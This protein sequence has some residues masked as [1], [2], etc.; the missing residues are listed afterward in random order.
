MS[1]FVLAALLPTR[2]AGPEALEPLLEPIRAAR[3][4]PALAAAV[5]RDGAIIAVG[6]TG[7]RAEG[8]S[9]RVT[10]EDR[11]HIGSCTKAMTATLAAILVERGRL[12]W[13]TTVPDGLPHLADGMHEGWKQA[14][15]EML[16]QNRGGLPN[17][18]WPPGLDGLGV[19]ML[20]KDPEEQ[21]REFVRRHLAVAPEYVPG[22]RFVYSNAGY[23]VAGEMLAKAGGASYEDLL[24][25]EVLS[26]L[27]IRSAGFGAAGKALDTPDQPWGHAARGGRRIALPPGPLADNPPAITP[28]GR[29]HLSIADWARFA[30]LHA[31]DGTFGGRRF[32]RAETLR[33]L[34]T[35][36]KGGD[37]AAG[38]AVTERLWGG[39]TVLTHAGSNTYHYAVAWVAPARRFA[40][41]AATNVAGPDAER[42]VDE[43]CAAAIRR[44]LPETGR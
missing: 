14:T 39:G 10:R 3:G 11:F 37:Y 29:V 6:A 17:A 38:W 43:A 2:A 9:A 35:P 22:T 16:L 36:P 25:K 15:L 34:H 7:L 33:R 41:V 28:A 5:T 44:F 26:P 42:A 31:G 40:V 24:L 30:A 32:L 20:S 8:K 21:R 4:V 19:W 13:E 1:P 12:R 27:G 23:A 18:T